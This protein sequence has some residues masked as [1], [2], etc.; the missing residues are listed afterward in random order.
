MYIMRGDGIMKNLR[1]PAIVLIIMFLLPF[2]ACRSEGTASEDSVTTGKSDIFRFED[3]ESSEV[4]NIE[5]VGLSEGLESK[6][7]SYRFTYLSDGLK[8]NAY[9]SIPNELAKTQTSG[10]CLMYNHGGNRNYGILEKDTTAN[11]CIFCGRIV[12]ASQY[13]GCGGSEGTD[14]FGGDDLNDVI[15]LIDLCE[16]N[17][18]FID[19]DDF[20]VMGASRGG[21]MTYEA[22]RQ[23]DRIKRIIGFGALTDMF[24][25]Y[26]SRDDMKKVL[27]D[28]IGCTPQENPDEYK[29]RSVVYWADEIDIPVLLIHSKGDKQV[30]Y[31]QAQTLY[32]KLKDHIDCR[33][34]TH[35][36]DNHCVIQK[37]D[38][39]A[40]REWLNN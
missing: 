33:L 29:K 15:R 13:R 10:K 12:V 17:F 3:Y 21:V 25:A 16:M 24:D 18:S 5:K 11:A 30:P 14:R 31:R 35:D 19:M 9:I 23:D 7:T 8:I 40:I 34:I 27:T 22:A 36:D 2:C 39:A 6:C 37:E 20:C 4:F 38:I 1:L 28:T 26:E 32:T